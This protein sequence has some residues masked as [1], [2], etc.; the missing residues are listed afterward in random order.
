MAQQRRKFTTE[1]KLE[2]VRLSQQS[3][4]TINQVADDLGIPRTT[5]NRWRKELRTQAGEAF[6]GNGKRSEDAEQIWR[7]QREVETL[8]REREILKKVLGIVSQP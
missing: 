6:R 4:K 7:L 8:K 2:A 5:L 1:Y 3:G